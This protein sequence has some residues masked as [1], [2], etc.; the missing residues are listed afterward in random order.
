[1]NFIRLTRVLQAVI[2][3]LGKR[4][5]LFINLVVKDDRQVVA[6]TGPMPAGEGSIC[7]VLCG[8]YA[9]ICL[10][11]CAENLVQA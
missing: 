5:R 8:S 11:G 9:A 1:M 10:K 6:G 2:F 3:I 7:S 4:M